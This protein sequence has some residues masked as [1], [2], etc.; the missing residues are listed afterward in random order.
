[1]SFTRLSLTAVT[2]LSVLGAARLDAQTPGATDPR[3]RPWMGCW[4]SVAP[5]T[6]DP[7]V[8]THACVVPSRTVPGSVDIRQYVRDTVLATIAIP[9]PGRAAPRT[10]DDCTGSET[11]QWVA[12]E[13]RLM[14]RADLRCAR[15]IKRTETALMTITPEGQWLQLQHMDVGTNAMTTVARFR[16]DTDATERLAGD[17]GDMVSSSTAR[18]AVS[19]RVSPTHVLELTKVA[20][21]GLA[22]AWLTEMRQPFA[23]DG[24]QLVALADAGLPARVVDLMVALSNPQTFSVGSRGAPV[25]DQQYL[26]EPILD[27]TRAAGVASV[28]GRDRRCRLDDDFCYGPYGYGAYGMGWWSGLDPWGPTYWRNGLAFSRFGNGGLGWGYGGGYYGNYYGS[29]PVIII[30][31]PSV[32]PNA[33][34]RGRAV[35]G[36]GYT[37][38]GSSTSTPRTTT[39]PSSGYGRGSYSAPSSGGGTSGGASSGGGGVGGGGGGGEART[40]KPRG[41][42]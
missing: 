20:P 13:T 25:A 17:L 2:L 35:N 41:G 29:Q 33:P 21:V 40:A 30:E 28:P 34:V 32:D 31:R 15:D 4:R 14:L 10:L 9:A 1:M 3:F 36:L 6:P 27:Q 18:L 8:P 37:R 7:T 12:D 42:G 11:S 5:A 26:G 39:S 19:G 38:G 24:K 16:F 22:E 23:I